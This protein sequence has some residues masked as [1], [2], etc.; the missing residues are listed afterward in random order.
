MQL[1]E[2]QYSSILAQHFCKLI[3]DLETIKKEREIHP[4]ITSKNVDGIQF[5]TLRSVSKS[6]ACYF[7]NFS[8]DSLFLEINL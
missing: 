5:N 7:G 1:N 3:E 6:G 4:D 8:Y 2:L